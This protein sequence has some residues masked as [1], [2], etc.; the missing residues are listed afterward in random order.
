LRDLFWLQSSLLLFGRWK[1]S[2]VGLP[3]TREYESTFHVK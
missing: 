2:A 1:L 3:A